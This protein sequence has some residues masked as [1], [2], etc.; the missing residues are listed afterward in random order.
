MRPLTVNAFACHFATQQLEL[1][2][3]MGTKLVHSL[4]TRSSNLGSF[5]TLVLGA[6]MT[7]VDTYLPADH[8]PRAL[9]Q[10][11]GP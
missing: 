11:F 1:Q 7:S 4:A 8:T 6:Q 2:A 9:Q 5:A 10:I 3:S